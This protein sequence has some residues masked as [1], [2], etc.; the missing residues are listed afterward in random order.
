MS[1]LKIVTCLAP[2]VY[3]AYQAI[4]THL[5]RVLGQPTTLIT[6]PTHDHLMALAPDVAFICGLPYVLMWRKE[7]AL[8]A[9]AAPVLR[10][11]RFEGRPIYFSDVVVRANAPYRHF[12]DLR[13]CRW[14]YNE[15]VSQSGYGITRNQLLHMGE[16]HGFFGEVLHMGWHERAIEAV[17]TGELDATAIDAQVLAIRFEQQPQLAKQLK[18]IDVLGPSSIQ[19]VVVRASL[20]DVLKQDIQTALVSMPPHPALVATHITCFVPVDDSQYDDIRAM[21]KAAEAA[22]FWRLE[23]VESRHVHCLKPCNRA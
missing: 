17:V 22:G 1:T 7:V 13:G 6:A 11:A 8:E 3:P 2:D 9:I 18:V 12:A 16:T 4:A 5:Q 20:P 10:G 23:G 14:G 19:P 15:F 21:V